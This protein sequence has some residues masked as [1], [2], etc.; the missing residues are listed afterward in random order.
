MGNVVPT[1]LLDRALQDFS[2]VRASGEP[3]PG[4]DIAFDDDPCVP[5]SAQALRIHT[6]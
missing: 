6:L 3:V 5:S 2:A 4:G 1:H